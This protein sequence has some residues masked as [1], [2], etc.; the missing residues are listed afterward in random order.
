MA[1]AETLKYSKIVEWLVAGTKEYCYNIDTTKYNSLPDCMRT[2][3]WSKTQTLY[4]GSVSGKH[5]HQKGRC[6]IRISLDPGTSNIASYAESTVKTNVQNYIKKVNSTLSANI[7]DDKIQKLFG[8][9]LA[10]CDD[11]IKIA[12]CTCPG[13]VDL[14]KIYYAEYPVYNPQ[15]VGTVSFTTN[16]TIT[17]TE[18]IN[19][20]NNFSAFYRRYSNPKVV[21]LAYSISTYK[22]G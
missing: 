1:L 11:N 8:M 4:A 15:S 10:Y 13:Y 12:T 22:V 18:M 7:T 9:I 20:L 2:A 21:P 6:D 19:S 16:L 5:G 3:N 14:N 17:A